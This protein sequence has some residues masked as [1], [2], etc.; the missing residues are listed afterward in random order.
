MEASVKSVERCRQTQVHV[1]CPSS[2]RAGF[3]GA[4]RELATPAR[5]RAI[6]LYMTP[7]PMGMNGSDQVLRWK[8]ISLH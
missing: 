8:S 4:D 6:V 2:R 5:V 1:A 3:S 7:F